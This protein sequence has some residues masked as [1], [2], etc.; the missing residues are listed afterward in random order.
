[1]F[2]VILFPLTPW[3]SI[4]KLILFTHEKDIWKKGL[5]PTILGGF[6]ASTILSK[7]RAE[8][9]MALL[10]ES[11]ALPIYF[12]KLLSDSFLNLIARVLTI[13]PNVLKESAERLVDTGMPIHT[14][15]SPVYF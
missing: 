1:M 7:G 14:S 3:R 12:L 10:K 15:S 8:C 13:S 11:A 2:I 4:G 9:E 5:I 6:T